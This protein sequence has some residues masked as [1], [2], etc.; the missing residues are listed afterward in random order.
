ME[1][2][3][4]SMQRGI[5]LEFC[6]RCGRQIQPGSGFCRVC[7]PV[8]PARAP[9]TSY[10]S[11]PA[12]QT[13]PQHP[14]PQAPPPVYHPGQWS[15][16]P[17]PPAYQHARP[18]Q[19][20]PYAPRKPPGFDRRTREWVFLSVCLVAFVLMAIGLLGGNWLVLDLD[21]NEEDF[22]PYFV[23]ADFNFG[24]MS[25][26][27]RLY[28]YDEWLML[29][30]TLSYDF[31]EDY[32]ELVGT[33]DEMAYHGIA[34][35]TLTY[36]SAAILIFLAFIAVT[37][38]WFRRRWTSPRSPLRLLSTP[39]ALASFILVLVSLTHFASEFPGAV[40][41]EL[42]ELEEYGTVDTHI[43]ISF[44]LVLIPAVLYVCLALVLIVWD[45]RIARRSLGAQG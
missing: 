42:W 44:H 10:P 18:V 8:G 9:P 24:L 22:E 11:G 27:G 29:D 17:P 41:S 38:F 21:V 3:R 31:E 6:E 33:E 7:G 13:W 32:S 34:S 4:V 28:F 35:T 12:P 45:W 16:R 26:D 5:E 23:L 15:P 30:Y 39:L 36:L 19:Q 14:P 37:F 25:A 43:G 1:S 2:S 40:E 20:G